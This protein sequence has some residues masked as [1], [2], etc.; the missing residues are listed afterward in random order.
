M[1]AHKQVGRR[2]AWQDGAQDKEEGDGGRSRGGK[3]ERKGAQNIGTQD[4]RKTQ[5]QD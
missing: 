3:E 1:P 5:K 4:M 2:A